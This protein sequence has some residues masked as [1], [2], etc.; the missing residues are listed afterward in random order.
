[1]TATNGY[2]TAAETFAP[3]K[4]KFVD[5]DVNGFGRFRLRQLSASEVVHLEDATG[6]EES[7]RSALARLIVA[8]CVDSEGNVIF[9]ET[10]MPR[11]MDLPASVVL[12]LATAC[13]Q[14]SATSIEDDAAKN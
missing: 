2:M 5:H 11:I 14:L 9:S 13:N 7:K 4:R 12:D 10:D 1:M 3:R 6:S 8:H